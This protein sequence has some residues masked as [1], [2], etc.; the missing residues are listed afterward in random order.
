[1]VDVF[2]EINIRCPLKK[3]S[4]YAANPENAPEWYV[5]I[6]SA[7]WQTQKPLALG[8]RIAFKAQFLGR[9][10][11]YVYEIAEFNPGQKL[12]MRTADG[13]FPMETTYTWEAIDDNLTKMTLRNK[14][15]PTGFS[16]LFTPFMA[17]MMKKANIKDLKKIKNLLES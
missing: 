11:A 9:Q 7:E 5:N 16:K 2:T 17:S 15:N 13:P 8:S 12:V 3:V 1:M 4:E 14:G 6:D 10:L